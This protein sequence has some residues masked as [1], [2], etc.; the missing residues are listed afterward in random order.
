MRLESNS[1][2]VMLNR[3]L[4]PLVTT[5]AAGDVTAAG[6]AAR[7]FLLEEETLLR[8]EVLLS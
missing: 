1:S 6:D 3:F 5:L 2:A 8:V 4:I 7:D